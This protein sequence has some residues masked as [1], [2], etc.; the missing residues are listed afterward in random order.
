M[1]QLINLKVDI[2]EKNAYSY[3]ILIG[4]NLLAQ[5]DKLVKKYSKANKFLIVTNETVAG[6]YRDSLKIDNAFWLV[7]KDGEEYKNFDNLKL[8]LNA[9][10]E[11]RLE[12]KDCIIAFG[13]GVIG[14]MAGF[15]AA[16]YMRGCDFIQ[17]PT[18][19]LAQ[20]DSSVGGKVAIN[21]EHGKNLIGAFYQPKLVLADIST[22]KTLDLR[23]LKTGLAEVLKYAF[24]EKSCGTSSISNSNDR[25]FDFLQQYKKDIFALK[26]DTMSRLVEI[27]CTLKAC[28]VN[29]D[30]TE[31]GLR[32]ILNFGHTYAHAIENLTNYTVYTHGEAVAMGMKMAFNLSL[33][34]GFVDNNYYNQ[35]IELIEHY[36]IAPKG[37]AFD[38]EKFY[39]EMFLDKKAQD[40]KVRFVLPNGHYSVVIVSDSSKEQVLDSLGL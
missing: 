27:C 6:L 28:V 5:A 9:A 8:I 25:L 33:K 13:G 3:D 2:P 38:K 15:A 19:L 29:Q 18:T 7:L 26:S 30:E 34:R 14:D 31:K 22:L 40:G 37:A 1:T 36:D 11:H 12:R 10:V 20:V 24:I 35:A 23:Q 39:D 21:H 16:S 32:A 17:I 4:E